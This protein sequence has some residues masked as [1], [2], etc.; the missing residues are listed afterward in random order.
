MSTQTIDLYLASFPSHVR[1]RLEQI[2]REIR[3]IAPE[4]TERISY[5]IPTFKLERNLVHYAGYAHHIGFYPGASGIAAF[6]DEL[7][8]YKSG[9]GSVQFPNDEPLPIDLIRRIV[10]WRLEEERAR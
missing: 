4:A 2:R 3:A 5:G 8:S 6:A 1:G 10:H 9:K 7:A